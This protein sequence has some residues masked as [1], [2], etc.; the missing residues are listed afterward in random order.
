MSYHVDVEL[1]SDDGDVTLDMSGCTAV[2]QGSSIV[3]NVI[4]PPVVFHAALLLVV[5]KFDDNGT[6]LHRAAAVVPSHRHRNGPY[7]V[8]KDTAIIYM[9][10]VQGT[11]D[12]WASYNTGMPRR[13]N[14]IEATAL[15]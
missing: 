7:D 14:K 4:Q 13:L 1:L 9:D 11:V 6:L 15:F 8:F 2:V 10:C 3:V 12:A 5:K